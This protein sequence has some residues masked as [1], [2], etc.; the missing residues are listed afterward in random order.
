[1]HVG[2]AGKAPGTGSRAAEHRKEFRKEKL[3]VALR[4]DA[5]ISDNSRGCEYPGRLVFLK[6]RKQA[7]ERAVSLGRHFPKRT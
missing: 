6:S 7:I 1:V 5:T 4:G 2:R 3:I